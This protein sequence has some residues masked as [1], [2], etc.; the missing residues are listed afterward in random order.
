MRNMSLPM[1]SAIEY[2]KG[3]WVHISPP[4]S[5]YVS[6]I[7]IRLAGIEKN[8]NLHKI[9]NQYIIGWQQQM[10]WD[11]C[12]PVDEPSSNPGGPHRED[13]HPQTYVSAGQHHL[14]CI[15]LLLPRLPS[16]PEAHLFFVCFKSTS[17]LC[18]KYKTLV[19]NSKMMKVILTMRTAR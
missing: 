19:T 12:G 7:E 16:C 18:R 2:P 9:L 15:C 11:L 14:L 17:L 13:T 6:C 4:P 10:F 1:I 3:A 8:Q 5:L